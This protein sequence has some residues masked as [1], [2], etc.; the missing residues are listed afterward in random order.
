MNSTLKAASK[1]NV[2]GGTPDEMA[3]PWIGQAQFSIQSK[4][5][6]DVKKFK[7]QP[8]EVKLRIN[9]FNNENRSLF[10]PASIKSTLKTGLKSPMSQ[11]KALE[12]SAKNDSKQKTVQRVSITANQKAMKK[13]Y[14]DKLTS[15]KM[16]QMGERQFVPSFQ[17]KLVARSS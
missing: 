14:N 17:N 13:Y 2:T 16:S 3:S 15:Q 12:Q 9:E 8:S 7:D 5:S 4:Q 1:Y 10:S 6:S 11:K